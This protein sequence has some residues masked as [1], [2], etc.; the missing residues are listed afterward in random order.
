MEN[1]INPL[2]H[3]ISK[4]DFIQKCQNTFI[5][6]NF[7]WRDPPPLGLCSGARLE[8]P[9]PLEELSGNCQIIYGN[10]GRLK[11]VQLLFCSFLG[12]QNIFKIGSLHFFSSTFMS[13]CGPPRRAC[14]NFVLHLLVPNFS[15]KFRK[16]QGLTKAKDSIKFR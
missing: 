13:E 8:L 2:Q 16:D 3:D 12:F 4:Q 9:N 6:F 14:L 1:S 5:F 15:L 10:R 7:H 11:K